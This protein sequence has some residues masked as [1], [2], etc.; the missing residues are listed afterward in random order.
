MGCL[1]KSVCFTAIFTLS[2]LLYSPVYPS[3]IP[4]TFHGDYARSGHTLDVFKTRFDEAKK[5]KKDLRISLEVIIILY[6]FF[7]LQ[8]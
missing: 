2:I 4:L 8:K 3:D 7:D 5:S 1:K 6:D